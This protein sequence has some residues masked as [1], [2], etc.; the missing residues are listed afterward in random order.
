ME[1][2][3][4]VVLEL[5]LQGA[6]FWADGI[7][8]FAVEFMSGDINGSEFVVGDLDAGGGGGGIEL[9]AGPETGFGRCRGG[10]LKEHL[11]AAQRLPASV[12]GDEGRQAMRDLVPFA[13]AGRQVTDGD[14]DIEFVG[15]L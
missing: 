1:G 12:G 5:T 11:M 3:L 14:R 13:G 8:P 4:G 7:I 15:Q 6:L 2:R 10:E 9:G